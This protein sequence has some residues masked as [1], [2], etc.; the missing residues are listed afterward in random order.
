MASFRFRILAASLAAMACASP[1]H[2]GNPPIVDPDLGVGPTIWTDHFRDGQVVRFVRGFTIPPG[3]VVREARLRITADNSYE[4]FL[5]GRVIGQGGDWRVLTEYEL[6]LLLHPGEHLL[7]VR[8]VNDFDIG[9]LV[10][11]L[12]V[13]LADGRV[14]DVATDDSW[15]IAPGDR[16]DWLRKAKN[17][18]TLPRAVASRPLLIGDRPL[19]YRAAISQPERIEFW[20]HRAF[21]VALAVI[22]CGSFLGGLF[23]ASRL[24]LR[25]RMARVVSRER[26]RI[27]ADLHDELGGGLTR[28][29]LLGETSRS[30]VAASR[31]DELMDRVCDQSRSL[32]RGMNEAVW[33]INSER[34]TFRDLAS[35]VARYAERFFADT[36]VRCRFE[37][38][39]EIPAWPC[40]IGTRRNLYLAAKEGLHNILRHSG[41]S[42][43]GIEIRR[44]RHELVFVLHDDGRGF[45]ADAADGSGN[46]LR[47]IRRRIEEAGGRL[48]I[49]SASGAGTRLE[50]R[51][52]MPAP[53]R[54]GFPRGRGFPWIFPRRRDHSAP[55]K[56]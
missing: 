20:Q 7:A 21:Q 31:G 12:R 26:A 10:A 37:V 43:A 1:L 56:A 47:N 54:L 9:G 4:V 46:G 23:L 17:W 5:D 28:L 6:R 45:E 2:A 36:P 52:P 15:R 18:K 25:Q 14:I 40:D 22:A 38:D 8:A 35:Y 48:G 30:G 44:Q 39:A 33:L 13:T 49:E 34:D 51:I 41:A 27:A 29:V 16:S 19:I 53:A 3:A 11:G 24:Y 55:T 50:F 32:L 42:T